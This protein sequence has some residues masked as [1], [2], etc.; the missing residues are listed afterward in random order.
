MNKLKIKFMISAVVLT[1]ILTTAYVFA[2]E[3]TV[4]GKDTSPT[5]ISTSAETKTESDEKSNEED[6]KS[7][8][9]DVKVPTTSSKPATGGY[10]IPGAEPKPSIST[11][12]TNKPETEKP[13][14]GKTEDLSPQEYL[15]S[16]TLAFVD[17]VKELTPQNPEASITVAAV[18]VAEEKEVSA[19]WYVNGEVREDYKSE[20]FLLYSGRMSSLELYQEFSKET[21]DAE[22]MIAFEIKYGGAARKIEKRLK[23]I[24]YDEEWYAERDI[25]RVYDNIKPVEIEATVKKQ[26]YT[27]KSGGLTSSDGSLDIGSRVYYMDH[28][29]TYAAKIWIPEEERE[30]WVPY[31]CIEISDKDYTV[32]EDFSNEDKE[33]FVNAKGYDSTTDYLI[34]V[35]VQR[36]KVNV[37]EGS[38]GN[39]HLL[40]TSTCSS[41]TNITPTPAGIMTYCA[42]SNGWFHDTYYVKPVMYINSERGIALHS[43]LF[44][45]NGTVQDGTQGTPAS[46]GC[47]RMPA[48]EI[49]WL[50]D[51]IPIGTTVVVF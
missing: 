46:H 1:V 11:E 23:I 35:N 25:A 21:E 39:W 48:E 49:R 33:I 12:K 24:N 15:A 6:V 28:R 16:F 26:T 40:R 18:R 36:Q 19:C 13:S 45:P 5:E 41:G 38:A 50:A 32:Y 51:Y 47:V 10:V 8:E 42:Y 2:A 22:I 17:G 37:F 9:E 34:W 7:D 31:N 30:C 3:Y 20:A 27:Y 43:I 29:G 44:N 4:P 14:V